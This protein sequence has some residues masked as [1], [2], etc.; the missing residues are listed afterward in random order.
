MARPRIKYFID[1]PCEICGVMV[2]PQERYRNGKYNGMWR[3]QKFC[4]VSCSNKG[5]E[6]KIWLD[7]NGY[8]Q[9]TVDGKQVAVHRVVMEKKLGRKLLPGETVHHKDGNRANFHESNLEL[10]ASRHGK[11][12]RVSDLPHVQNYADAVLCGLMSFAA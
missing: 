9:K 3:A 2:K 5:R 7:K 1:R 4:S 11:G 8:P 6:K 10:W 12:Q